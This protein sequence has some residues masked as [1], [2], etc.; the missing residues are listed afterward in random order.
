MY[1][2]VK[3]KH[4]PFRALGHDENPEFRLNIEILQHVLQVIIP[5]YFRLNNFLEMSEEHQ[6]INMNSLVNKWMDPC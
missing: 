5:L 3:H 1:T 2:Y 4:L 6:V